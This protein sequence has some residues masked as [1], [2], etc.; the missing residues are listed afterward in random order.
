MISPAVNSGT[1]KSRFSAIAA[2]TNSARSVAMAI[3]SAWTQRP[4][5]TG[6]GKCSRHSSGRLFPVTTPTFADRYWMSMAI[7]LATRITH[8]SR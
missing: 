7:R 4:L 3:S 8:S 6:R 1:P 5:D 2:P